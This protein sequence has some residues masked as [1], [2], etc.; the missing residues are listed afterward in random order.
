MRAYDKEAYNTNIELPYDTCMMGQSP[1]LNFQYI[2]NMMLITI[3][4]QYLIKS[5]KC[6]EENKL[7][8]K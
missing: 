3:K 7:H 4:Q 6:C 5:Y 2:T 1:P 8:E